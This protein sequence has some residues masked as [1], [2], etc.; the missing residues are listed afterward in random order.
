MA[1]HFLERIMIID[2]TRAR[3]SAQAGKQWMDAITEMVNAGITSGMGIRAPEEAEQ[4]LSYKGWT[5][6]QGNLHLQVTAPWGK[7]IV[8]DAPP[9]DWGLAEGGEK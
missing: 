2:P 1:G 6:M 8:M 5:D 4:V 7:C 3:L 9:A